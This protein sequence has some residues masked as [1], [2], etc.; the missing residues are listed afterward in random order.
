MLNINFTRGH[1]RDE[2]KKD[3]C[4]VAQSNS[5][6]I[7]FAFIGLHK[8]FLNY[9]DAEMNMDQRREAYRQQVALIVNDPNIPDHAK[10]MF[11]NAMGALYYQSGIETITL[12]S[13][14]TRTLSPFANM[15]S[16]I[17]VD[18]HA[19]DGN[20]LPEVVGN[21]DFRRFDMNITVEGTQLIQAML[22]TKRDL[23]GQYVTQRQTANVTPLFAHKFKHFITTLRE[24]EGAMTCA[25]VATNLR[26]NKSNIVILICKIQSEGQSYVCGVPFC[27]GHARTRSANRNKDILVGK[28]IYLLGQEIMAEFNSEDMDLEADQLLLEE[29]EDIQ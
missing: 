23:V 15:N 16:T 13:N 4:G 9:L 6:N 2:R 21:A 26:C 24:E 1:E 10:V 28:R 20:I 19:F 7:V 8:S 18:F 17:N 29:D 14:Q 22:Y 11:Q 25:G 5:H 12:A 3:C 27:N